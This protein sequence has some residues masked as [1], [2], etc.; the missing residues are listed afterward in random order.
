MPPRPPSGRGGPTR[1]DLPGPDRARVADNQVVDQDGR[2]GGERSGVPAAPSGRVP[3]WVWDEAAG[4]PAQ[5]DPWRAH[6]PPPPPL[7]R[8]GPGA[9]ARVLAVLVLLLVLAVGAVALAGPGPWLRV[10]PAV[11]AAP[12]VVPE[13][14]TPEVPA[15]PRDRPT[16]SVE[17]AA[18]PRGTPLEPPADGGPHGFVA[19]QADGVTPVA[20]DP[21]RPIHYVTD[22]PGRGCRAGGEAVVRAA[23]APDVGGERA[24]RSSGTAPTD[25]AADAGARPDLPAR[26]LRRPVGA[27]ATSP[28]RRPRRRTPRLAGGTVGRGGQRAAGSPGDGVRRSTSPGPVWL[29]GEGGCTELLALRARRGVRP[30]RRRARARAR[31]RARRTWPTGSQLMYAETGGAGRRPRRR[32]PGAGSPILGRGACRP[33]TSDRRSV[34]AGDQGV[35]D[36]GQQVADANPHEQPVGMPDAGSTKAP[37]SRATTNV[38]LNRVS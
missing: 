11:D 9:V 26:P 7:G 2:P 1:A 38:T 27:G 12:A 36:G 16:G 35:G 5:P 37:T 10:P 22:E 32:R 19:F 30:G 14:A 18:A 24:A 25:E 20:Y 13:V 34:P 31:G 23:V 21:C 17:E 28:A 6:P 15:P 3:Q 29:D 33:R 4:F 8:R